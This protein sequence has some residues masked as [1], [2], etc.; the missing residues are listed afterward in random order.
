MIILKMEEKI[1][2]VI[3]KVLRV[4]V[5]WYNLMFNSKEI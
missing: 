4:A 1:E 5:I 3:N 2:E